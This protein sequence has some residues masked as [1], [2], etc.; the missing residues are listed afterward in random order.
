MKR[1]HDEMDQWLQDRIDEDLMAMTDEREKLLMESEELQNIEMPMERLQDI[2][3]EIEKRRLAGKKLRVRRRVAAAV[4]AI[5][6]AC[7]GM[8]LVGSGTKLYIP[9]V[10]EQE[11]GN[12]ISTKVDN[13][14][15]KEREYDEEEICQEI[16]ETLGVMPVRF[17]YRPDGIYLAEYWIKKDE[18]SAL[19]NYKV[20]EKHLY[21]FISK[22]Y[23]DSSINSR[24]DGN[25]LNPVHV[26][27]CNIETNIMEFED[28]HSQTYYSVSFEYLNTYYTIIGGTDKEEFIKILENILIKNA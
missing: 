27:S 22:D 20:G 19:M 2:H 17:G 3:R 6:V 10:I 24:I 14:E 11:I 28:S 7:V 1:G 9:E 15:T 25:D 8:G 16:T 5:A 21:I 26:E 12:D 18:K 4:A 13:S 23:K